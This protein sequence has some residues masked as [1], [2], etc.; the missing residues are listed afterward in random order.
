MGLGNENRLQ[1][2]NSEEVERTKL[3]IKQ[4]AAE[5]TKKTRSSFRRKNGNVNNVSGRDS[6]SGG[7]AG[8]RKHKLPREHKRRNRGGS[9]HKNQDNVDEDF[10]GDDDNDDED[11]TRIVCCRIMKSSPVMRA[12]V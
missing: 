9:R 8:F 3:S 2:P 11:G 1:V 12:R 10:N 4:K 7:R 5:L 6:S